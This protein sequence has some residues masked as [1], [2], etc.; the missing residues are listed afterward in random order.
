MALSSYVL[1][2]VLETRSSVLTWF[3]CWLLRRDLSTVLACRW[4]HTST[5]YVGMGGDFGDFIDHGDLHGDD[6]TLVVFRCAMAAVLLA[7]VDL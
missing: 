2:H 4:S 5:F 1:E 7:L 3:V 6:F